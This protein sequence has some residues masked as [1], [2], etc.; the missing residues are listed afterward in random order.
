MKC[1]NSGIV[2]TQGDDSNALNNSIFIEISTDMDL[3]GWFA[4][5]QVSDQSWRWN[6]IS[7]KKLELIIT[8]QQSAA[9][10]PGTHYAGFKIFDNNGLGKT[11]LTHTPTFVQPMV[12][13]P[14]VSE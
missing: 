9:L 3:T 6:D 11:V 2:I 4:V 8:S 5:F 13:Q 10:T 7:S 1:K 12:V 14:Q